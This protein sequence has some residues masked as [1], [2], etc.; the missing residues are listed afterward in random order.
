MNYD[1]ACEERSYGPETCERCGNDGPCEC[2][3][4]TVGEVCFRQAGEQASEPIVGRERVE[5]LRQLR[6]R[7]LP[8]KWEA[9]VYGRGVVTAK[10]VN[11]ATSNIPLKVTGPHLSK[12]YRCTRCGHEMMIMTNHWGECYSFGRSNCCP[13]CPPYKKYPEYGGSTVWECVEP[14]PPGYGKP[15]PWKAIKTNGS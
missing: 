12:R 1:Q 7:G 10:D 8:S 15:E 3:Q 13:K 4:I 11:W 5:L 14:P 2:G 9:F 6:C